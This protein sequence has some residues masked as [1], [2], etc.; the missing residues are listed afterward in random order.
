MEL[1]NRP[2]FFQHEVGSKGQRARTISDSGEEI[3]T[4]PLI[5]YSSQPQLAM[6]SNA[7]TGAFPDRRN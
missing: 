1:K 4:A 5:S 7:T 2:L 6:L 3:L